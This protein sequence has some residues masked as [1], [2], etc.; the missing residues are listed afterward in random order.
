QTARIWDAATGK[1]VFALKGHTL[2]VAGVAWEPDGGH[3]ITV[4]GAIDGADSGEVCRW[5]AET[6]ELVL[7]L[8]GP[9][10]PTLA[11]AV[12]PDRP[13]DRVGRGRQAEGDPL[14][15]RPDRAE[16]AAHRH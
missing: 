16:A 11:V 13:A 1:E 9:A 4:A 6:G 15:G 14:L 7:K 2:P 8:V 5:D 10:Q 3:L 12:S